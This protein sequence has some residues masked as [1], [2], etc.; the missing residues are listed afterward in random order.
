[1]NANLTFS[2]TG[3]WTNWSYVSLNANLREG[4]NDI[5]IYYASGAGSQNFINLDNLQVLH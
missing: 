3:A 4:I 2:G 1:M 5:T